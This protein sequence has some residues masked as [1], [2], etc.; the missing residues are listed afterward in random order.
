MKKMAPAPTFLPI[1][2]K[3]VFVDKQNLFLDNIAVQPF[4]SVADLVKI[5]FTIFEQRGDPIIDWKVENSKF[6]IQ[7][8]LVIS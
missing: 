2:L 7:G 1:R 5:I 3:I 4:D 8:P 6:R